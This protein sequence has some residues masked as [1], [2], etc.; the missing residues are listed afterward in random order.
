MNPNVALFQ[1]LYFLVS[2]VWPII[3]IASFLKITGP[4]IDLWLVKTVGVLLSVIGA[5]LL[6]AGVMDQITT[7]IFYLGIGSA[8]GLTAIEIIYVSKKVISPIYLLDAVIE[9]I[10]MIWWILL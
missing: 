3:H 9:I 8:A 1:G 6:C 4:K 5:V 7:S 2:G 10:L